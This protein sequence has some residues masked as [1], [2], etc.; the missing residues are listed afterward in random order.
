MPGEYGLTRSGSSR[1][2]GVLMLR[3]C[4]ASQRAVYTAVPSHCKQLSAVSV[5]TLDSTR[6]IT[7]GVMNTFLNP[8]RPLLCSASAL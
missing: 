2:A 1:G 6:V 7:L 5:I 3:G 8:N 4:T